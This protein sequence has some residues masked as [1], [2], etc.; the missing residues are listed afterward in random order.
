MKWDRSCAWN[1]KK[2]GDMSVQIQPG[3]VHWN[4]DKHTR[5]SL[6]SHSGDVII[7][8]RDFKHIIFV[9]S[10]QSDSTCMMLNWSWVRGWQLILITWAVLIQWVWAVLI[11][12]YELELFWYS[13]CHRCWAL[14][15]V[16]LCSLLYGSSKL[17][18][19]ARRMQVRQQEFATIKTCLEQ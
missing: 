16:V 5:T 6:P 10:S 3:R 9:P 1:A 17:P 4:Q 7:Y 14:Q 2:C 15:H 12:E 11:P 13:E 8:S 19:G 18:N